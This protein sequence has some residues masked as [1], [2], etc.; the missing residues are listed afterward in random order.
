MA[1][2]V[3]KKV[4]DQAGDFAVTSVPKEER[5]GFLSIMWVN[6]G[7][8]I[9]IGCIATG[10]ALAA[11]VP[12]NQ[13]MGA[14]AVGTGILAVI[15]IL[16][17]AIGAK[18]GVSSSVLSRQSYGRYGSWLIGFV[19]A[20]S[21]GVGWFGY[22]VALFS[23]TINTLVPGSFL[24]SRIAVCIWGG[25][26][27][28]FTATKGFK[29]MGVLSFI[30]V[31]MMITFF[32]FGT[33][34]AVTQS[35]VTLSQL[36]ADSAIG[37]SAT[38]ASAV[39]A[40]VGGTAA[41]CLGMADITRYA[42]TPKQA[43][44]SGTIGYLGGAL[45]CEIAGAIIY[46]VSSRLSMGQ[47][48][49]LVS[50]MIN[51]GFGF[52]CIAVLILAQWTTNDNNLYS[53]ALGLTNIVKIKKSTACLIM[54][55]IGILIAVFNFQDYLVPF[56]NVL[57]T[58]LPPMGGIILAHHFIVKPAL[59]EEYAI[60]PGEKMYGVNILAIIVSVVAAAISYFWI[61]AL[62]AAVIG[63][64]ISFIAYPLLAM[65]FHKLGIKF[66]FGKY[67]VTETGY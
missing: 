50:A 47:T 58:V 28:I 22:Q 4:V 9:N 52:G 31:P 29:A 3:Q 51:L 17:G 65:L 33:I 37:G 34:S 55:G 53:G 5:K 64:L 48:S 35:G 49:D 60:N 41:G 15:A 32:A 62:P 20:V 66:R 18:Y 21:L 19:L 42:K 57:G 36:V 54:G 59:H 13:L 38:F 61:T 56:L 12:L 44:A 39:T 67:T 43:A 23:T 8:T 24:T 46:V 63:I 6:A 1:E 30:A 26:L 7:Y 11:I 25:L 10:A 16:I 2:K 45:F 14:F 27:M 40:V